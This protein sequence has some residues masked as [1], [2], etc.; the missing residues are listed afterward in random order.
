MKD[1]GRHEVQWNE[2]V[3]PKLGP[4][5]QLT[6][7]RI[8]LW[9]GDKTPGLSATT[10]ATADP[11]GASYDAPSSVPEAA[12]K[13]PLERRGRGWRAFLRCLWQLATGERN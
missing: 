9:S 4:T 13:P 1:D 6:D 7:V 12:P 2:N 11:E 5:I 8:E 10:R 3:T